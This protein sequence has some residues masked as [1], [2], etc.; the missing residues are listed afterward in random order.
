[1]DRPE[2]NPVADSALLRWAARGFWIAA[3]LGIVAA[4]SWMTLGLFGADQPW[5]RLL[6]EQ[7]IVSGRHP[8]HLYHGFLGARSLKERGT[9]C[10]Y[11][12]AF[13][14]GYPKTPVFD[15]S[16]RPA[17]LF[18]LLAGGQ[19]SPRAYK[20]GL[21]VC[22]GLVPLAV[23]L[24]AWGIGLRPGPIL[25]ASAL[26]ALLCWGKPCRAMIQ[27]GDIDL[28]LAALAALVQVGLLVRFDR[29][30]GPLSWVGL[31]VSGCLGCF[32]QPLLFLTLMLVLL[33]IYYLGAGVRH[34]FP[35]HLFLLLDLLG[36][37]AVNAF[38]LLDWVGYWWVLAPLQIGN[39]LLVH[40]T[41]HTF[42]TAAIWGQDTDRMLALTLLASGVVGLIVFNQ[43]K[44]RTAARLLGLACGGLLALALG[45]IGWEPL[46]R[47]GTM[48]LLPPALWFAV[49]P[50]VH[51]WEECYHGIVRWTGRP[52]WTAGFTVVLLA[53]LGW[54][55]TPWLGS[56]AA[57]CRDAEPLVL[58]WE[59]Q[60]RA[61]IE[62]VRAATTPEARILWEDRPRAGQSSCWT[63]LLP[64]LTGRSFLGGLDPTNMVETTRTGLIDEQL[65]G[66]PIASWS[67]ADL[68]E[69]CRRY[70]VGWVV[71][72]SPGT[73]RRIRDW[74]QAEQ[75]ATLEDDGQVGYL[76]TLLRPR[77]FV[78]K[79]QAR[80]LRADRRH[81]TLADVVPVAG[82]VVLSLHYQ[83]GLT[84]SPDRVRLEAEPDPTARDLVPF[85]RLR[86]PGPVTRLTLTWIDP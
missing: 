23:A 17:E 32:A 6:D 26:A 24:A 70:N 66:Q 19:F 77:S 75:T 46:G 53:G 68:D 15:G 81:I 50:A 57:R 49:L 12:P 35:W 9:L 25:L 30:P 71:G 47:V 28:L 33:P 59:P 31:L 61:L 11:D 84:V 5:E 14:A 74:R 80:W 85:V 3:L 21:A 63:A 67:D 27:A 44:N 76:F 38:W 1:M 82:E 2:P 48:K 42:W 79:G 36:G 73:I 86:V 7:P 60:R 78:L 64:I 43:T 40:R 4:Q 55:A 72:W 45:A 37:V 34:G 29:R 39:R 56:L 54:Q 41:F 62:T 83:A 58:G 16:S 22:L 69:F 52:W 13:Q 65:I 10:C 51:A 18:L 20:I 8:L